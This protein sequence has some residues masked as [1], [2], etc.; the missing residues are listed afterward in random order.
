[1]CESSISSTRCR[2]LN[3]GEDADPNASIG[4][5][6]QTHRHE[7]ALVE[8]GAHHLQTHVRAGRGPS[9][10]DQPRVATGQDPVTRSAPVF[11]TQASGSVK[12]GGSEVIFDS[13]SEQIITFPGS[14]ARSRGGCGREGHPCSRTPA[15][16]P[17]SC[18]LKRTGLL[19][20]KSLTNFT[21]F[22]KYS[23]SLGHI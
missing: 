5:T 10:P 6:R 7:G 19:P 3:S 9:C 2:P 17:H 11:S 18:H 15:A 21:F 1:M 23:H 4:G 16:N 14:H 20:G 8:D 12:G 22:P 13:N